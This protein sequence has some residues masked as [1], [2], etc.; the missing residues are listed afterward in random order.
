MTVDRSTIWPYDERG[1]PGEFYYPR[2]AHPTGVEAE[3]ALGAL[4]GGHALLFPSGAAR[5][6]RSSLGLLEP[7]DTIALAEG[8]YFGT[9]VT[10]EALAQLGHPLRRVRP[11]RPAAGRRAARLARGA[12]EPVPDD[13][14]PRSGR[15]PSRAAS[16]STRPRRRR[17]TCARSSTAPTSCCTAR[18]STSAATPTSCSAP[19]SAGTRR[20]RARSAASATDRHVAAPD[21]AWLL[22]RGLKTLELRVRRQ[23]ET[24]PSLAERLRE[25]PAVQ[26]VRYPGFGGLLS[27]DVADGSRPPV[28]PRRG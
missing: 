9:G 10:F 15:R 6:R 20:P 4:D 13:A 27:F 17:S 18:R 21:P 16:S 5:R 8:C 24:A 14:G 1:E 19:S 23:S 22:L 3:R 2:Y 11:D 25:H 7:G 26:T 12:V 28:E